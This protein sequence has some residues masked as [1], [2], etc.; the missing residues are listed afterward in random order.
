MKEEKLW[1]FLPIEMLRTKISKSKINMEESTNN[2]ISSM[3]TNG[4][5]NQEKE[6]S[7]KNLVYTSKDL[8]MLF[9]N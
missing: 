2:G 7:M 9:L 4:K 8:S 5:V 3:L 1:T 6:N